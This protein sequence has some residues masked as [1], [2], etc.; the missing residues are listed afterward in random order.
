MEFTIKDDPGNAE[1]K[2]RVGVEPGGLMIYADGHGNEH[3]GDAPCPVAALVM[4]DGKLRLL[5]WPDFKREDV[6][7]QELDGAKAG[8]RSKTCGE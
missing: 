4:Q 7:V 5:T 2:G 1:I 8:E 3:C 6:S